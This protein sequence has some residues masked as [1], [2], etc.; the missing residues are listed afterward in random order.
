MAAIMS[1]LVDRSGTVTSIVNYPITSNPQY[2]GPIWGTSNRVTYGPGSYLVWVECNVNSMKDNYGQTG[3]TI[4][5]QV[6]LLNQNQNP[7][8][9]DKGYVTNPTTPVTTLVPKT[10][11]VT[12]LPTQTVITTAPLT[13]VSTEVSLPTQTTAV[14]E[15]ASVPSPTRTKS[16]GFE[17]S[18]ALAAIIVGIVFFLKKE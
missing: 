6:S 3:K 17:S 15:T 14:T 2:T 16:P 7:L 11:P 9:N 18:C 5:R 1:E 13:T 12:A 8:I 10:T 4:S